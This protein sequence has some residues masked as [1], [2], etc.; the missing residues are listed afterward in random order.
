MRIL[1]LSL[2]RVGDFIMQESIIEDLR[3][4]YPQAELHLLIN[5]VS[6]KY[7]RESG[8][9]KNIHILPRAQIQRSLVESDRPKLSAYF[10][11]QKLVKTLNEFHFD[12][13]INF[14]HTM[15]SARIMDL[16]CAGE[17]SGMRFQESRVV[18]PDN[19]W[20]RFINENF[21]R[22]LN[23]PFQ[24]IDLLRQAHSI[25]RH[26][27][28]KSPLSA[29]A[30]KGNIQKIAIQVLTS[31]Q[32]K[33]WPMKNFAELVA[34]MNLNHP[35]LEIS[36][37]GAPNEEEII[38]QT[39]SEK[40]NCK[41]QILN[42]TDLKSF[43]LHTDLLITGDTSVQHLAA[44]VGTPLVSLFLGSANPEKTAPMQ[45]DAVILQPRTHCAPCLHSKSCFRETQIC[46]EDL[47]VNCVS[48]VIDSR[49][50]NQELPQ[51]QSHIWQVSTNK[52][53]IIF[54]K[55]IS[56]GAEVTNL[57]RFLEQLT[58]QI[59]LDRGHLETAG[60][61]GSASYM[62]IEEHSR[63]LARPTSLAVI[64]TGLQ[65]RLFEFQTHELFIDRLETNFRKQMTPFLL[66][67]T[68]AS[69]SAF[70]NLLMDEVTNHLFGKPSGKNYFFTLLETLNIEE[71]PF[72]QLKKIKECLQESRAL[73]EIELKLIKS[74]LVE[75]NERNFIYVAR[76]RTL[77]DLSS[78]AP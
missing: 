24:G 40:L 46:A 50:L 33:N 76:T 17:K 30:K 69:S 58:W 45:A 3:T 9:Y 48:S 73:I 7:I 6:E 14:S 26:T 41:I 11:L 56:K 28:H 66:N 60:P 18:R 63:E 16:L 59:Y 70:K 23:S 43:L 22:N 19:L 78:A 2:L 62:F 20:L 51:I 71:P 39:F 68:E 65:N 42:W 47:A 53:G 75:L 57:N 64:Q 29:L 37:L 34:L 25:P 61:F 12:Q 1:V 36:I 8:K 38:R 32:K 35:H 31:D 15:F 4:E 54:L 27:S 72:Q 10:S 74:I 49:I 67:Q 44:Q 55:K 21:S 13:I 5:D 77:F 52:N